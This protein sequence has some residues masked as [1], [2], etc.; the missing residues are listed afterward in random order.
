VG[1][2]GALL[3][4]VFGR[5]LGRVSLA[6]AC[7]AAGLAFGVVMNLYLWVTFSGEHT[8]AQLAAVFAG[9]LPFDLAHAAGNAAFCLAFGPALVRALGRYRT[10]FEVTWLPAGGAVA[11]ALLLLLAPASAPSAAHASTR[12]DAAAARASERY[13]LGA[14][15]DDGGWG[16]APG[17]SS[18]QLYTGWTAL[19]LASAGTNPLDA[20][21]PSAVEYIRRSDPRDLGEVSRTVLVLAAAGEPTRD[22][23]GDLVDAQR[24]NG[25]WAGRVN[26]TAFGVLAL[27]AGGRSPRSRPVRRAVRWISRQANA[28]GGFNCCGRGG[29][30]GID[31]TGAA[32]QALGAAKRKRSR[33]ARRGARFI[34][35]NQASDGGF[36]LVPGGPSNAQSTAWAVQGLLAVGRD[37]AKVRRDGS[38]DPMSYLRSLTAKSGEVRYSRSST[39]TPVWVTAQVVMALS[40]EPLPLERVPRAGGAAAA[41]PAPAAAAA[42]T[43]EPVA[44]PAARRAKRRGRPQP[45]PPVARATAAPDFTAQARMAGV[46]AAIAASALM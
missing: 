1:V 20:G 12:A 27:R 46:L 35:R 29:Q 45:L 33:A 9:S 43:P 38:R 34:A 26:T 21:E 42:A 8:L 15:N 37:P 32:L 41:A 10:R 36:A 31:D 44:T 3:A 22:L 5:E 19:G 25:S 13:L 11:G 18:S 40:R 16:A 2:G 7:A 14:Q 39:Q 4:R 17:Q 23:V 6:V 28:D 30:S 24:P